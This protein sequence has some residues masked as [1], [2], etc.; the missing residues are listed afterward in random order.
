MSGH[1]PL[2]TRGR[3][4]VF[5]LAGALIAAFFTAWLRQMLLTNL[6]EGLLALLP[7]GMAKKLLL[8]FL[9]DLPQGMAALA[10]G[11]LGGRLLVL[12][13]PWRAALALVASVWLLDL[14]TAWL[15]VHMLPLWLDPWV[16][17][18]RL[19]VVAATA[20]GIAAALGWRPKR[21]GTAAQAAPTERSEGL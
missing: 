7:W 2:L 8:G 17:A 13:S 20:V 18:S 1:R 5:L 21:K 14:G 6:G 10:V 12:S 19:I 3:S 11:A 15:V 9:V 4:L 16:V